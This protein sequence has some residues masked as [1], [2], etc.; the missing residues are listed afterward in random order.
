MTAAGWLQGAARCLL[1]AAGIVGAAAA[2]SAASPSLV[3]VVTPP[4]STPRNARLWISGD[5]AELGAWNGAGLA[6]IPQPDGSHAGSLPMPPGT[7]LEFK[8]TRGSWASVEKDSAGGELAN[9][10]FTTSAAAETLRIR[11]ASWRD[12]QRAEPPRRRTI[13]GDV[14]AHASFPS[15]HV[16]ARNV[17]VWLPPGY[18]SLRAARYPVLYFHDGQNVLDGGTSFLP[19][20][21][22]RADETADRLIRTGRVPAFVIVAI[23]NTDL[24]MSEYTS[25]VDSRH[26]GGGS[27]A[28]FRFL[29]EELLPFVAG[30]YHVRTDPAGTGV[31][32]SSLGGLAALECALGSEGRFGLVGCVSPSVSWAGGAVLDR[33]GGYEGSRF[34]IWLDIG[35]AEGRPAPGG[36]TEAVVGARRLRDALLARGWREGTDLEYVEAEGA[37]HDE[38]AWAARLPA[39]MTWLFAAR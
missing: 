3:I 32:G 27:A 4:P 28:Y 8:V 15:A 10:R 38:D 19:G 5:R 33:V 29:R 21:E 12:A 7:P 37:R 34:R 30:T 13:T 16:P 36:I 26:G 2:A 6:L 20:R 39:L 9:R 35:T 23:A 31:I 1:L 24:R 17:L 25:A 22:W 11:V 14:R 18:D